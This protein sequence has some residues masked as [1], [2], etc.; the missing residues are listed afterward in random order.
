[1]NSDSSFIDFRPTQ[2]RMIST[3]K[4]TVLEGGHLLTCAALVRSKTSW[5]PSSAVD[6]IRAA[7][8]GT[9]AAPLSGGSGCLELYVRE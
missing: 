2:S 4:T 6:L 9:I 1:L 3:E 7:M 8:R 5:R